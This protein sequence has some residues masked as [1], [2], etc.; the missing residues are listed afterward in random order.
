MS[1]RFSGSTNPRPFTPGRT[2]AIRRRLDR[3]YLVVHPPAEIDEVTAPAFAGRVRAVEA[4]TDIV[5]DLRDLQFCGSAGIA[6]LLDL[7]QHAATHDCTLTLSAPPPMFDRLLAIC[8]L[9][10]HFEVRRPGRRRERRHGG[11]DPARR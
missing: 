5:I 1:A 10:D 6:M 4:N 11:A 8:G 3:S 7:Q 9:H 2:A